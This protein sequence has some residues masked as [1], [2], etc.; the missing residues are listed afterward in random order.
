M[1]DW[2]KKNKQD[3]KPQ[4]VARDVASK[5]SENNAT[6]VSASAGSATGSVL[7]HSHV[8]EKAT[9]GFAVNQYT[10]I[11]DPRATKS[12]VRDA[13][14]KAYKVHV[15]SVN[16]IRRDGKARRIGRFTGRS[17]SSQKAIVTIQAGQAITSVQS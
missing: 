10:F 1:F 17:P 16:I 5:E 3:P 6:S 4:Q 12:A 8:S 14:Q 7:R 2:F 13:V 11:V 9:R 15:V